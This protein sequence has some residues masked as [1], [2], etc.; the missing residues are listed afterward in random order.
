MEKAGKRIG[1]TRARLFESL[2]T[3]N[4]YAALEIG[5]WPRDRANLDALVG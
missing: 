2:W 1:V 3:L 4:Q 5:A